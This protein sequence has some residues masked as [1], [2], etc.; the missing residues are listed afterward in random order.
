MTIHLLSKF[1]EIEMETRTGTPLPPL[2]CRA[3]KSETE[4]LASYSGSILVAALHS[5]VNDAPA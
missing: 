2:I 4:R 5:N 3:Q 1:I